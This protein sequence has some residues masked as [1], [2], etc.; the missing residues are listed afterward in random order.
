MQEFELRLRTL[1]SEK[2]T[3][4]ME[5]LFPASLTVI[6]PIPVAICRNDDDFSASFFD[7]NIHATGDSEQEA[8]DGLREI[9]AAKFELYD[10]HDQSRLG[11]DPLRQIAVL[12]QYVARA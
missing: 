2:V 10:S 1:E 11:P 8:F 7:A 6:K 12:R 3:I 4:H 9:I 5:S